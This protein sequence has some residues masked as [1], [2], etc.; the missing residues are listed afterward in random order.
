MV[1]TNPEGDWGEGV[2]RFGSPDDG[3]PRPSGAALVGSRSRC[4]NDRRSELLWFS[5]RTV[6]S[7]C[8]GLYA[9]AC[10]SAHLFLF[11]GFP[12]Y[13]E[14]FKGYDGLIRS[15]R[16][17]ARYEQ[18]E[19]MLWRQTLMPIDGNRHVAGAYRFADI[20][21]YPRDVSPQL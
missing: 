1:I 19:N 3:R 6:S 21:F 5:E 8:G 17:V 11:R 18:V 9:L 10:S 4:G 7:R 15:A 12:F 2:V 13:W 14:L 20:V 16:F